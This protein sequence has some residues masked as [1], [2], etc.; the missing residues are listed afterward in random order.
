MTIGRR[1]VLFLFP[2][3]EN[4]LSELT[5]GCVTFVSFAI[6]ISRVISFFLQSDFSDL[7]KRNERQK[8]VKI[9]VF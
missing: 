7:P 3:H 1:S 4:R 6:F 8:D 9:H 2:F 5:V